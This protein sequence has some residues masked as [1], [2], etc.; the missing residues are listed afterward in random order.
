V[1]IPICPLIRLRSGNCFAVRMME[2]ITEVLK[3][4]PFVLEGKSFVAVS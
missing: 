1:S 3:V 4:D 2:S